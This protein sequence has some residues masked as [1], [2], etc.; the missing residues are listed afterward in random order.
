MSGKR[1]NFEDKKYGGMYVPNF[2]LLFI[3]HLRRRKL[4]YDV[5]N[6]F[7]TSLIN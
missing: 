3:E 1:I 7:T 5:V 6:S 4:N 2:L